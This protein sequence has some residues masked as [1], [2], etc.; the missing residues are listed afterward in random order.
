[1]YVDKIEHNLTCSNCGNMLINGDFGGEMISSDLKIRCFKCNFETRI[2]LSKADDYD[3]LK[4]KYDKL[5]KRN[6]KTENKLTKLVEEIFNDDAIST[7]HKTA[8][9][10]ALLELKEVD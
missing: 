6:I 2:A 8:Y 10:R 7:Q 5:V 1:M 9:L 4:D 3:F